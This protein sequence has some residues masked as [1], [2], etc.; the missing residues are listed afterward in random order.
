MKNTKFPTE[1]ELKECSIESEKNV[2]YLLHRKISI[3]IT[4]Y[5]ARTNVTPNQITFISFLIALA[6]IP[7]F[8][9]GGYIH[10][11]IGAVLINFAYTM[12]CV[13]GEIAKLKN[14]RSR[15]GATFDFVTDIAVEPP[16]YFA[17]TLGLYMQFREIWIWALGFL[18][19]YGVLM[20]HYILR[21]LDG[22]RTSSTGYTH[23]TTRDVV[24]KTIETI[25]LGRIHFNPMKHVYFYGGTDYLLIL[26]GAIFYSVTPHGILNSMCLVLLFLA[27]VHNFHWMTQFVV[28]L[29]NLK[30]AEG[31]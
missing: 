24:E 23:T 29:K 11:V 31:K 9:L 4:K 25:T 13:D 12:D 2:G 15:F 3:R 18:V 6:A 20:S 19:I 17:I 21:Y 5:L 26:I 8:A 16:L 27:A 10:V 22:I 30:K 7:F 14:M 28:L 1:K